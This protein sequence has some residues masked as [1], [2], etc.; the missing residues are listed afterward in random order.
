[1][2][3]F[4]GYIPKRSNPKEKPNYQDYKEILRTDFGNRCGYCNDRPIGL[5]PYEID[6][7]VPQKLPT[8]SKSSL[9]PNQYS[10][11]VFACKS[12][13]R[14]KSNKWPTNDEKIHNSNN[15]GFIDPCDSEYDKHFARDNKGNIIHTTK[16]GE[17]IYYALK[18]HKPQHQVLWLLEQIDN[19]IDKIYK[20]IEE[21]SIKDLDLYQKLVN[22][23]SDY[24]TFLEE[25]SSYA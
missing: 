14:S 6:H 10:N 18:F 9:P 5:A 16:L 24:R 7:F 21:N 17:W 3:K 12:C 23:N 1:M 8:G 15:K 2:H 11:L 25:L 20:H 4:R 13:N 19:N 22:L